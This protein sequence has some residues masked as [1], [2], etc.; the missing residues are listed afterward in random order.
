MNFF[1]AAALMKESTR[2]VSPSEKKAA[3]LCILFAST[4]VAVC[5]F[6]QKCVYFDASGGV[7]NNPT[8]DE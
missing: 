4:R 1:D 2:Q 7:I 3:Q 8:G 6:R 5:C